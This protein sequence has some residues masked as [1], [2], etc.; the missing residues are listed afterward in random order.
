MTRRP[1]R[2]SGPGEAVYA[3]VSQPDSLANAL[4]GCQAA[5]YLVHSLDRAEFEERDAAA[6]FAEAAG[7]AQL[8]RLVYLGGLGDDEDALSAHLRS[9]RK[10]ERLLA[11]GD[12]PVTTLRAGIII[13]HGGISRELTRQLAERLPVM[14]TPR[15]VRT[16]TQPIAVA[17]V[18]R[19]LV[20]VVVE[21]GQ[22]L[23]RAAR[24]AVARALDERT[25]ARHR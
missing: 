11:A 22:M 5:Y 15:W 25:R 3:D 17:D 6:A 9:R 16:R 20:A 14:I 8:N 21:Y 7:Q 13:G 18:V 10:V 1:D 4:A 23:R 12:V 24:T 2:Y 19:Y